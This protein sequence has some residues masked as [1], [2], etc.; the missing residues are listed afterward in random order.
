MN[1]HRHKFWYIILHRKY[2]FN[3]LSNNVSE[4]IEDY[5]ILYVLFWS[6]VYIN[7]DLHIYWTIA[8]MLHLHELLLKNMLMHCSPFLQVE[9]ILN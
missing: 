2:L 7:N 6:L 8:K 4:N 1:G 3:F 9:C 5:L